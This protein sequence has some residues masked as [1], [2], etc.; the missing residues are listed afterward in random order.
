MAIATP[1][2]WY[3]RSVAFRI[4]LFRFHVVEIFDDVDHA[5]NAALRE[6]LRR[7]QV[8]GRQKYRLSGPPGPGWR[9]DSETPRIEEE[10]GVSWGPLAPAVGDAFSTSAVSVLSAGI[11]FPPPA[12]GLNVTRA[13]ACDARTPTQG[14]PKTTD[15]APRK[16][17]SQ[18]VSLG[19]PVLATF[20]GRL[21]ACPRLRAANLG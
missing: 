11:T 6:H 3:A 20:R 12:N 1:A 2:R 14:R 21:R 17:T 8:R 10:T 15:A 19:K 18:S 5:T 13:T 9:R 4:V 7:R 16:S